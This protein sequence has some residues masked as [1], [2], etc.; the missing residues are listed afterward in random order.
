VTVEYKYEFSQSVKQDLVVNETSFRCEGMA[1]TSESGGAFYALPALVLSSLT[2]SA[3][4]PLDVGY[5]LIGC[6]NGCFKFSAN[7]HLFPRN[8]L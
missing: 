1:G 4:P 2:E 3:S 5:L 7:K 6:A 8:E